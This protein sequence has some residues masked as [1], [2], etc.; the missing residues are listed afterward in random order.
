MPNT[1]DLPIIKP[2]K[3][4]TLRRLKIHDSPYESLFNTI[5]RAIS[6]ICDMPIAFISFIEE[7]RQ[8]FKSKIG[9]D[10]ISETPIE[11]AFCAYT[12]LST[13]T[14][15]VQDA[16]RDARFKDNPLVTGE[17]NIRFYA[18]API[19]LPLGERIGSLSVIDTKVNEL[20][21]YKIAALEGFAKVISQSLL[22]RDIHS[23]AS[24]VDPT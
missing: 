15:I 1:S 18:G 2:T 7:D 12:I 22:I 23:R 8:W 9:L 16:T 10:G 19:T 6:E 20:D 17:T 24:H 3:L 4:D 13:E 14:M 5:T 21:G 11:H